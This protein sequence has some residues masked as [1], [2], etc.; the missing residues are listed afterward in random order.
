[1]S[2]YT[3]P[4][5]QYLDSAGKPYVD[6]L[7]YFY[8][9]GTNTFQDTFSDVNL[10]I[11]NAN[12][13][14]L[15]AD[16]RVPNIFLKSAVYNVLFTGTDSVTGLLTQVWQ[17]DSV[18]GEGVEGNFSIWNALTVYNSP[19]IVSI[20]DKFYQSITN[21]NQG[22]SPATSPTEWEE[23]KFV[24][25]WN[26][27]KTYPVEYVVQGSNGFLFISL[28]DSNTGNDPVTDSVNWGAP[29]NTDIELALT[30]AT[31]LSF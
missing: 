31:A 29:V 23:I 3:N 28:T 22:N 21:Q 13:V 8:L 14:V 26:I 27:N 30:Q 20:D 15:A 7:I 5:P 11:A 4:V 18:G 6:G 12:P 10:S 17:R 19:D 1:M 2:R 16:G 25:V 9:S 24:G